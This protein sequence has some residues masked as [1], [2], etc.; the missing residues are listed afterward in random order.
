VV[1][2]VVVVLRAD[3]RARLGL[4]FMVGFFVVTVTRR[5]AGFVAGRGRCRKS[6]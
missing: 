6:V 4:R 5:Q 1:T 3:L 2:R